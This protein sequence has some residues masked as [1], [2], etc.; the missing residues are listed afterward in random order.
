MTLTQYG[1]IFYL[2]ILLIALIPAIVLGILGKK[3]KYYG[4]IISVPMI[5]MVLGYKTFELYNFLFFIVAELFI[6]FCY[7]FIRKKTNNKY[8][9]FA[10]L[11]LSILPLFIVKAQ[12]KID[13]TDNVLG[14]LGISY[15]SFKVI[16]MVI[17]IYDGKITNLNVLDTLYFISFFPVFSSGPIDRY[18]RFMN[19]IN[20]KIEG[21]EYINEYLFEGLKKIFI[22]IA[23]KFVIAAFINDVIIGAIPEGITLSSTITYMYAYTLYLFFDFAGYSSFAVGTSYLLG[24]KTPMN[25]DKPFLAKDMKEFWERWHITLSKWLADYLFSRFVLNCLRNNIIKSKKTATR[26][27]LMLTMITMGL[28]HGFYVFYLAYGL[29]QGVMLVLADIYRKTKFYRKY[30]K[31][32]LFPTVSRIINFHIVCFGMLI[33]SG[34]LFNF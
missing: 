10:F 15:I 19:N 21:S 16:Q 27:G 32:T 17:E 9:Y 4:F 26:I 33:F 22:G 34:Y 28:W 8:I 29:Y 6:V 18:T 31:H 1:N 23:Y 14:F 13:I 7:F 2:Y 5:L 30:K 3:T 11:I 25:F 24:V 20:S 12:S